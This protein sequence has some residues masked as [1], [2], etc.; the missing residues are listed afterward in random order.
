MRPMDASGRSPQH[1]R[2]TRRG[3]ARRGRVAVIGAGAAGS[4]AAVELAELG[5][6][7]LVITD[8]APRAS[9]SVMAQGGLHVPLDDEGG[10]QRMVADMLAAAGPG[11]DVDL[12]RRFVAEI[13]PTVARL[14]HWG[15]EL[16]R[17]DRG[18]RVRRRAGGMSEPRIV[19]SG[20]RIGPVLVKLL[21]GRLGAL[22]VPV[23]SHA[24]VSDLIPVHGRVDVILGDGERTPVDAVVVATGGSTYDR[25]RRSGA[26]TT[27][28][29][30]AN[31]TMTAI[32]RRLGVPG[33][34]M[35]V[36]QY[37]P[38]GL[39]EVAAR[40]RRPCVP[41]SIVGY[42]PRLLDR[43]GRE[44]VPIDAGRRAIAEAVSAAV[45][46]GDAIEGRGG[47]PGVLLTLSEVPVDRLRRS[48]P[49]LVRRLESLDLVGRD[50]VV[51]PC[52]HYQLGGLRIRHD[53]STVVPGVYLA[54][55]IVG[56][57]HGRDRLMGNA[58]TDSLVHG[59]RA[60][61]SVAAALADGGS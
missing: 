17:D 28:P 60:A 23:R 22:D 54:G 38:F 45:A 33:S 30:N 44:V 42:G 43:R 53:C 47:D 21:H 2:P 48:H 59:R 16:D 37:Q 55:E 56:G 14:E 46:R 51:A 57:I 36:F 5:L 13:R 7:P 11:V 29:A 27:N 3:P 25:A 15:L 39:A 40:V 20:D 10:E 50:V 26:A 8:R 24:P 1:R 4:M 12:V 6:E 34:G 35:G 19:S 52:L 31:A 61:H 41:E 9:N 49:H 18:R 58:L 32:L